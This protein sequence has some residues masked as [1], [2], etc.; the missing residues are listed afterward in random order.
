MGK[1]NAIHRKFTER[2]TQH[3]PAS[4]PY[5][6]PPLGVL[7]IFGDSLDFILPHGQGDLNESQILGYTQDNVNRGPL[8]KRKKTFEGKPGF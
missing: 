6:G 8:K 7:Q 2:R 1:K 4:L 5:S 3:L